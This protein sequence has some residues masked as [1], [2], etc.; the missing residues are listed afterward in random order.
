MLLGKYFAVRQTDVSH[1]VNRCEFCPDLFLGFC[2]FTKGYA[3][4]AAVRT[5]FDDLLILKV[6][7]DCVI[8]PL[9]KRGC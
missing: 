5:Y 2:V 8:L 1:T 4:G 6:L 3:E 7:H 9:M